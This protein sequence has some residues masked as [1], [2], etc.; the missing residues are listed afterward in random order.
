MKRARD[1]FADFGAG[2]AYAAIWLAVPGFCAAW[3]GHGTAGLLAAGAA[4]FF[5]GVRAVGWELEVP[6]IEHL[7]AGRTLL[8]VVFLALLV[9][10]AANAGFA[11]IVLYGLLLGFLPQ[12]PGLTA[13]VCILAVVGSAGFLEQLPAPLVVRCLAA[14]GELFL[15]F[16]HLQFRAWEYGGHS[17][18]GRGILRHLVWGLGLLPL[19]LLPAYGLTVA[20]GL[21]GQSAAAGAG[22]GRPVAAGAGDGGP[23]FSGWDGVLLGLAFAVVF[24]LWRRL[25][26]MLDR[27]DSRLPPAAP[28]TV[29]GEAAA[30][31]TR[32]IRRPRDSRRGPN[33]EALNLFLDFF[34]YLAISGFSRPTGMPADRFLES[35]AVRL[36]VDGRPFLQVADFFNRVRYGLRPLG[37]EELRQ[38]REAVAR[39]RSI[40]DRGE[41]RA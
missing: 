19:A 15:L 41:D 10:A 25:A 16:L 7:S 29:F 22:D 24:L 21:A 17:L 32:R 38:A 39:A 20:L 9:L 28:D 11:G 1:I 26:G 8:L 23:A 35:L 4:V 5:A 31:V 13:A 2:L 40:I 33:R 27:S 12:G 6:E 3:L 34:R 18:D 14:S 30:L 37:P 36:S